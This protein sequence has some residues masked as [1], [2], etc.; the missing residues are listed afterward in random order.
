MGAGARDEDS[1]VAALAARAQGW[2]ERVGA[3]CSRALPSPPFLDAL[4]RVERE[5]ADGLLERHAAEI[6]EARAQCRAAVDGSTEARARASTSGA[7]LLAERLVIALRERMECL[8]WDRPA[9]ALTARL[10]QALPTSEGEYMDDPRVDVDDRRALVRTLEVQTRRAGDYLVLA[11][12][13]PPL[14]DRLPPRQGRGPATV[15]DIGSGPGGFPVTVAR[16][17][18][19]ERN[20]RVVA[21]DISEEYLDI[22]RT[23]SERA[24]VLPWMR[25]RR[26]DALH[27]VDELRGFRPD[28]ITCT[29]SL[30]HFGIRG[31]VRVV[32]QALACA[33]GGIVFVDIVRSFSRMLMAAGAGVGS[34]NWRFLHDAVISVRKSFSPGELRL[35]CACVPGGEALEVFYTAPAY[36]VARGGS[37]T[38]AAPARN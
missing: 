31:T 5:I 12:L 15:L 23:A 3:R 24:Q 9:L 21:T 27:L 13:L 2:V 19:A 1:V 36:V 38:A 8:P 34:G 37:P 10:D 35:V 32:A 22:A 16:L 6:A 11:D 30:H 7:E 26:L 25:F 28:V 18:G 29:R 20:V 33:A 4:A 14:L 17:F